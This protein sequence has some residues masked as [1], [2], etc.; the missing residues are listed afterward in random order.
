MKLNYG[1]MKSLM[2]RVT[3]GAVVSL[4]VCFVFDFTLRKV[5]LMD[6][7]Y[8]YYV[9][10][11]KQMFIGGGISAV[12]MAF[13]LMFIVNSSEVTEMKFIMGVLSAAGFFI[14][15]ALFQMI[16]WGIAAIPFVLLNIE[17][18]INSFNP[19]YAGA[20]PIGVSFGFVCHLHGGIDEL[21]RQ[22]GQK[23][24]R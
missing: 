6:D 21:T 9:D 24:G 19:L 20:L 10:E 5:I 22:Y 2:V 11:M 17:D 13:G 16:F 15:G 1:N 3:A 4:V 8:W 18:W 7:Y 14:G 23:K 12:I